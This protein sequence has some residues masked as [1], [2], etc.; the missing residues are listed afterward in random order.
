MKTKILYLG[1][2]KPYVGEKSTYYKVEACLPDL[3]EGSF[4]LPCDIKGYQSM[5][6]FKIGDKVE[7]ELEVVKSYGFGVPELHLVSAY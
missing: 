2:P 6:R 3:A 1:S 5:E 7:V 4:Q